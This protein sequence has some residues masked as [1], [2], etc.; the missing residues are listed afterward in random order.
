MR[1]SR[2][3]RGS[4][5]WINFGLNGNEVSAALIRYFSFHLPFLS[6]RSEG[7]VL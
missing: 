1:P 3:R 7:P 5:V 6:K 4:C 2:R